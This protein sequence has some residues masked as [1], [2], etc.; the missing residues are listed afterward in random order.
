MAKYYPKKVMFFRIKIPE[1]HIYISGCV[2]GVHNL[3]KP[4][5]PTQPIPFL[6]D[7]TRYY[8]N[9]TLNGLNIIKIELNGLG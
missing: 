1:L 5:K 2:R 3:T 9:R 8:L 6:A 4:I 7:P